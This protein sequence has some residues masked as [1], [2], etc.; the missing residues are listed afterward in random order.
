MTYPT[1]IKSTYS[2]NFENLVVASVVSAVYLATA[3]LLVSA[4][5]LMV[6]ISAAIIADAVVTADAVVLI[7]VTAVAVDVISTFVFAVS[8]AAHRLKVRR[9]HSL[10]FFL[11]SMTA[12][13]ENLAESNFAA[14]TRLRAYYRRNRSESTLTIESHHLNATVVCQVGSD[15]ASFVC[16]CYSQSNAAP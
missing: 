5:Q 6:S 13:F 11:Y 7:V 3:I 12:M 16:L 2:T 4:V 8:S 10:L 14:N 1:I 9:S 15:S